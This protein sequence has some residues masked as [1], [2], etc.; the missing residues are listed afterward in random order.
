MANE[1]TQVEGPYEAHDFTVA[2]DA[3][4]PQ[5]T[6]CKLTDPRTAA[7][8]TASGDEVAGI[9]A[10]EK[11]ADNGNTSLG[12]FTTGTFVMT[13]SGSGL[14]AGQLVSVG[15]ANTIKTATATEV[16]EGKILGKALQDISSGQTGEVKL[17]LN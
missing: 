16:E 15:G 12:L 17:V 3:G 6:I 13:D 1:V 8:T 4:I 7:A 5:Y 10:T 14:S 11:V 2:E 9:A